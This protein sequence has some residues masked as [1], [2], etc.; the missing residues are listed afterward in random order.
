VGCCWTRR[1][2][3]SKPLLLVLLLLLLLLLLMLLLTIRSIR[4]TIESFV[5]SI[6]AI[7]HGREA[8][9]LCVHSALDHFFQN[10]CDGE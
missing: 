8:P 3:L 4:S 6:L 9:F 1:F 5:S 7:S 10:R 2:I